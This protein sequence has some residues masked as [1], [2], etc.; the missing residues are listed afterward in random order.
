MRKLVLG[1]LAGIFLTGIVGFAQP[2]ASMTLRN[3]KFVVN[4]SHGA[5]WTC[6]VF[7][8]TVPTEEKSELWPDGHYAPRSCGPLSPT[9]TSFVEEFNPYI[10]NPQTG[11]P[12]NVDWDVYAFIQ[13]PAPSGDG[14]V[15]VETNRVRYHR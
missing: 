3:D 7:R 12:Y 14:Y 6:T 5:V 1:L 13:Y 8:M 10:F 4:F 11:E 15:D 2:K 9:Q